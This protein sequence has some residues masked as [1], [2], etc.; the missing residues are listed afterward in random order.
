MKR[1]IFL[2]ILVCHFG[3][4]A[5]EPNLGTL[6]K[7][8]S[9]SP[10]KYVAVGSVLSAGVRDGGVYEAAQKTS[11]PALL[12]E[13]MGIVDFKQPLLAGNGTGFKTVSIDK[14]GILKF[15]ETKGLDDTQKNATLPRLNSEVDNLSVPYQKVFDIYSS[16][17]DKIN[18]LFDNRSFRHL[19]R[20]SEN[21]NTKMSYFDI[22]KAKAGKIDFF[23]FEFGF[24]DFVQFIEAGGYATDII[25][26][27]NRESVG[28][29]KVLEILKENT[30]NGVILNVPDFLKFPIFN[31]YTLSKLY[32]STGM[33][34]IY[35][36]HWQKTHIR[37]AQQGDVFLPKSSLTGLLEKGN[38]GTTEQNPIKDEDV[39]DTDEQR[40]VRP[41]AYN[42][43]LAIYAKKYNL[44]IV[45]LYTVYNQIL[46][47]EYITDEGV[48]I[49]P[50]FPGGNFFSQDGITPTAL[51][52][53]IITNEII[54][55][56][57][58]YYYS[59]IPLL[60]LKRFL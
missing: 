7:E 44:P 20:F 1:I 17:E 54:K 32:A 45:D 51:G 10:L 24:H 59:S 38:I 43:T 25:Y 41:G 60:S 50:S 28:E 52:Q 3:S 14:N 58:K 16:D 23:T 11:F 49:D 6:K 4:F 47:G 33:P 8:G 56:I 39:L 53:A 18:P 35:I 5:Q 37:G 42:K 15:Q 34:Q 19:Q 26:I 31:R 9:N 2:G 12:A 46:D 13:Q 40:F 27:S 21:Q 55:V 29:E 48:T 30:S 22:L 36:E 57:N